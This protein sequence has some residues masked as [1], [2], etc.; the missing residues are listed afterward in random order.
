MFR[1]HFCHIPEHLT[2]NQLVRW[3]PCPRNM[4]QHLLKHWHTR[5]HELCA[6]SIARWTG[7]STRKDAAL[8]CYVVSVA[9]VIAAER[10]AD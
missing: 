1:T 2:L 3:F 5:R 4:C 9:P 6:G 8:V 10:V 7:L